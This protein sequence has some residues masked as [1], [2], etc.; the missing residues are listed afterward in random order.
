MSSVGAPTK[1]NRT[2][3]SMPTH[4]M[5][6]ISSTLPMFIPNGKMEITAVI[7]KQLS[8]AGLKSAVIEVKL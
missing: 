4:P 3:F 5:V 1:P 6:V 8:V 2:M 7:A